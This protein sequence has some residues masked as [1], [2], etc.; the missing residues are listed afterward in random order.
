[1]KKSKL[2]SLLR[3]LDH[4]ELSSFSKYIIRLHGREDVALAVF[5][6]IK[7][8]FPGFLDERKLEKRYAHLRI[9]KEPWAA[10]PGNDSKLL[11]AL[12]DLHLWLKEFLLFQRI[13]DKS[14]E[15]Q[16]LWMKILKERGLSAELSRQAA[17]LHGDIRTTARTSISDYIKG[18]EAN[19]FLYYY[20]TPNKLSESIS[21]LQ[22][23]G[24]DMDL[25]YS[26]SR[27]KLACEMAN[28]KNLMKLEYSQEA[29]PTVIE[30]SKTKEL[31]NAPL[32]KLYM[33]VYKLLSR[34]EDQRYLEIEKML[35]TYVGK[36]EQEELL[37]I[38]SY[39]HNYAAIQIRHGNER[40]WMITHRLNKFGADH[41]AFTGKS[42]I[43]ANQLN[44][45][46]NT[47]CKVKDFDWASSFIKTHRNIL[48]EDNKDN[49]LLL[50]EAIILVEQKKYRLAL[51]KLEKADLPEL[52]DTI[53]AR[54]LLL[55]CHYELA[56]SE[57]DIIGLCIAFEG[58][59]KR[60]R[61][62]RLEAVEATLRFIRMVKMLARGKAPRDE[63]LREIE[64]N[65]SIYFKAWLLEKTR[66]YKRK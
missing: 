21:T 44:S 38:L 40:Y 35:T 3:T 52:Y 14:F 2:F 34:W 41:G 31:S 62:P 61:K 7:K 9:F 12:S 5:N 37:T 4:N 15:T 39:L 49:A 51:K 22:D 8:F 36:I 23:C 28:R 53:R 47:A 59:L 66:V 42:Q 26:V 56:D 11:N 54:S 30:L 64:A 18:M 33:A 10:K 60:H 57:L 65:P 46:V 50:A 58:Y 55:I 63:I 29:L 16:I 24:N 43:T 32:L 19:Y 13:S 20:L 48:P 1:M 6:Y 17:R 25:F 27:V 45:I